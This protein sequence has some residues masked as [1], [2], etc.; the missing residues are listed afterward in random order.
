MNRLEWKLFLV[1]SIPIIIF[2]PAAM[3]RL[4]GG[5]HTIY[6]RV[7][8]DAMV[9]EHMMEKRARKLALAACEIPVEEK[10]RVYGDRGAAFITVLGFNLFGDGL[11]D[12]LDPRLK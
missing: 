8:E 7:T 4:T 12:A 6:G 9:R 2:A 11:W 3:L 5:E 10:L 1:V